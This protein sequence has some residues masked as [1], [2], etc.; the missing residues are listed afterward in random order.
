MISRHWIGLCK[1]D[2][3]QDYI[4]HLQS[5]TFPQLQAIEGFVAAHI[6][7]RQLAEGTEFLITTNWQS[8]DAIKQFAGENFTLAVVPDQVKWMMITYD[9]EVRHY[10]MITP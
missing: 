3:V 1:K 10:E 8:L 4:K 2:N 7:H 6:L 5:D 9:K